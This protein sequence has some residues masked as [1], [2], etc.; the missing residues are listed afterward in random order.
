MLRDKSLVPFSHQHQHALALSVEIRR[1]MESG[2]TEL[3]RWQAEIQTAFENEIE[4]HFDAEEQILFPVAMQFGQL[5]DLISE[6]LAEHVVL[7][8]FNLAA[9]ARSLDR[10]DLLEFA[11]TL[12]EHVRKEEHLLF[13]AL[14]ELAT[15]TELSALGESTEAFFSGRDP[16]K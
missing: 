13:E 8:S 1:A 2:S 16:G 5:Q 4:A 12:S 6:L 10:K 15:P 14:Q 11:I 9:T 7:R 3:R